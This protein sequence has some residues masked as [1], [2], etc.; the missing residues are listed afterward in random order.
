MTTQ[1]PTALDT[2]LDRAVAPGYSRVG[3]QLRSRGWPPLPADTLRGRTALVTGANSGIGKAVATGLARLGA[4]VSLVVRDRAR[5]EAAAAEITAGVPGALVEVARCDVAD[6]ASVREFAAEF[7]GRA[8]RVDVLVHNA[9]V[10]PATR[11]ESPQGHELCL[12]THVLGPIL[13]TDLLAPVLTDA[14]VVLMSSGG[15]YTQRL[16]LDDPEY[17]DGDYRGATAYARS[18]RMQVAL[19]PVLADRYA[20]AGIAVHSMHPGWVDTPGVATSLPRFRALTHPLL[21]A[22][23][24]GAD[25][26][27]WLAATDNL[28]SGRFWHDRRPRPEHYTRRTRESAAEREHLWQFCATAA[29][30]PPESP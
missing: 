8:R 19:T 16:H 1:L 14:R 29:G 7:T 28:P 25:T 2:A 5:G 6:L 26:A 18:K 21:R 3:F 20:A 4:S 11:T 22:P 23:A 30:L 27:V 9:G 13:L 15:M 12:A 17:R 24:E 10:L